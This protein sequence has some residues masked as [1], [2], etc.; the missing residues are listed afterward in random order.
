MLGFPLA[1]FVGLCVGACK[2]SGISSFEICT[3]E[4]RIAVSGFVVHAIMVSLIVLYTVIKWFS[5]YLTDQ[6]VPFEGL[7]RSTNRT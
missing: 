4:L 7:L 1:R 5:R 2:T 3:R 6:L